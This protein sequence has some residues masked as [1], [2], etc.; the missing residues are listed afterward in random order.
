MWDTKTRIQGR[1][2]QVGSPL[3]P[4]RS[5]FSLTFSFPHTLMSICEASTQTAAVTDN[6]VIP[7]PRPAALCVIAAAQAA[8]RIGRHGKSGRFPGL[9]D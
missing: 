1:R 7:V 8:R 3:I 2:G 9:I 6:I 5:G 4:A